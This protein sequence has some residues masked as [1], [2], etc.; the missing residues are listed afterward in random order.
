[1]NGW[2]M[3]SLTDYASR[4][5]KAP[6]GESIKAPRRCGGSEQRRTNPSWGLAC[7]RPRGCP[8]MGEPEMLVGRRRRG[9]TARGAL[10]QSL[11]QQIWLIHI[12]DRVLPPPHRDRQRGQPDRPAGELRADRVQDLAVQ[13]VQST[14]VDLQHLQRGVRG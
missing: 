5:T 3:M 8:R 10:D 9:P 11:L 1:M 4:T 12:L 6:H 2:A 14:L 7:L 13:A